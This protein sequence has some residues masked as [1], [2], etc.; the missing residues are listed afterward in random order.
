[1][2]LTDEYIRP[3]IALHY[4]LRINTNHFPRMSIFLLYTVT[5]YVKW[6]SIA[7]VHNV[8]FESCLVL[9]LLYFDC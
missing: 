3:M 4:T 1:M 2:L 6:Y 7:F 9:M 5:L 8:A